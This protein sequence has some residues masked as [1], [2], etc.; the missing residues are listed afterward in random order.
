MSDL[1]S[2]IAHPSIQLS[3]YDDGCADPRPDD[4]I[5]HTLL[6]PSGAVMELTQGRRFGIVLQGDRQAE[7]VAQHPAQGSILKCW[8]VGGIQQRATLVIHWSRG[9]DAHGTD[10]PTTW[11]FPLQLPNA[12]KNAFNDRLRALVRLRGGS[13]AGDNG[14]HWVHQAQRNLCCPQI[15]TYHPITHGPSF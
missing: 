4:N 1:P 6:A 5:D 8:N 14:V 3:I 15:D 9:A 11:Q 13:T 2:R 10:L 7:P 12:L